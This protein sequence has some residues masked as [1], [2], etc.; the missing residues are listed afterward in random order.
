MEELKINS[1][2]V[3]RSCLQGDKF[4]AHIT[5]DKTENIEITLE[6]SSPIKIK[7]IYNVPAEGIKQVN[8]TKIKINKFDVN[9]Y[10]GL[11][12]ISKIIEEAKIIPHIKFTIKKIKSSDFKEFEKQ[13]ILFKPS[14]EIHKVP[15]NIKI[16]YNSEKE[17]YSLD[18]KIVLKNGGD[19][20]AIIGVDL[21]S[22]N[23]FERS[24][25]NKM[26]KF[27]DA[28]YEDL[29]KKF[30]E[31][32]EPFPE[33]APLLNKYIIITKPPIDLNDEFRK[34]HKKIEK[35][36]LE[37]F[38]DDE[39][40]CEQFVHAITSSYMKN[41][42]LITEKKSFLNYLDSVGEGKV[43]LMNYLDVINPRKL[44]GKL[45]LKIYIK[46]LANN[47]HP[48]IILKPIKLE[49]SNECQIPVHL[50]FEWT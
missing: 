5:W 41:I 1:V 36:F 46:D 32:K 18:N 48:S 10:V 6:Y 50:L 30:K 40:F 43:I 29:T 21:L 24:V 20:T 25:H 49:L 14:I 34:K 31:M 37:A 27:V 9:G 42:H 11:V 17:S 28:V 38:E 8:N 3:P 33:Y 16:N 2:F 39:D 15:E 23:D 4:P 26:D 45:E 35:A 7:N 44:S 19:G 47:E 13:I 22:E 12:F